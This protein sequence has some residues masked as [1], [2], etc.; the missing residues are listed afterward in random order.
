MEVN[1]FNLTNAFNDRIGIYV[2]PYAALLNHSCDYNAVVSFEGDQLFIKPLRPIRNGE[3]IFISY[4]DCT[5]PRDVRRKELLD[6]YF[7]TCDCT[8]CQKAPTDP[9]DVFL[10]LNPDDATVSPAE[11]NARRQLEFA[12]T[13]TNHHVALRHLEEAMQEL[14]ATGV[15]P[16][17]RQPHPE[18]RDELFVTLLTVQQYHKA[19]AHAVIRYRQVD[20]LLFPSPVHPTR[21]LHAWALVRLLTSIGDTSPDAV[22]VLQNLC[23]DMPLVLWSVLAWLAA[24][25]KEACTPSLF[26]ETVR[27]S[28]AELHKDFQAHG[29]D[30]SNV[31]KSDEDREWEKMDQ[32]AKQ[33]LSNR[34]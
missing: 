22:S 21:R 16:I 17:T 33:I 7:F 13:A 31:T 25:E 24:H 15:W 26:Q 6:R 3:Q 8:K 1:T 34:N 19:L 27:A 5:H 9:E 20:P 29:R 12:S 2:H 30:P 23:V 32:F 4:V 10:V 28:Q 14:D 18:I 11:Q